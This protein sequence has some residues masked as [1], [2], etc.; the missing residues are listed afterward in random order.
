MNRILI[1]HI[2]YD[3]DATKTAVFEGAKGMDVKSFSVI[4]VKDGETVYSGTPVEVGEVDNWQTGYYY[5]MRFDALKADGEYYISLLAD[6]KEYRSFPFRIAHNLLEM[7][8]I[9]HAGYY[10]K[11][12]RAT[13]EFEA[14]DRALPFRGD[15]PG[16]QDVRGGWFDATGD[17]GIHLSHLSHTTY[18]NPQQAAFSAYAFFKFHDLLEESR[19][20]YYTYLKRRMLDEAM[21]GADFIMRM[22]APSGTFLR[23]KGRTDAFLP[24][25]TSRFINYEYRQPKTRKGGGVLDGFD[26]IK[27]ENYEVSFRSG[28]GYAIATLAYAARTSFP[29]DY[30][31][32]EYLKAAISAYNYLEQNNERYTNDGKWNLIDEYCALD[33][34][35]ELYKT[36]REWDYMRKAGKMAERIMN[37]Y[38][39]IDDTMGYLSVNGTKRPFFHAAD[40]GMPV[41]NLL[42]Y[43]NI[44]ID[45]NLRARVLD[46]VTKLMRH[47]LAV[48]KEVNNPFGYARQLIQDGKGRIETR[49]FY[50]HDVETA[51]WWQ[52]ENARI[53]SLS[54]AARYLTYYTDCEEFKAELNKYADD[55]INWI[56]G[57]NPY[58]SCMME[59]AGRNT[60]EYFFEARRDFIHCPGGIVNGITGGLEDEEHGIAFI[61]EPTDE[62]KDNW[63][64]A[65]QW[66]PHATWYL[67]ALTMKKI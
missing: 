8:T 12:Q 48:T 55:Q 64:W 35:V 40:A 59:G 13:G 50:P 47:E 30:P 42:N 46:I 41:V 24:L 18:F 56:L 5:T 58:D 22:R 32:E 33:A 43:Y 31:K 62:I 45:E 53:A 29:S 34:L 25:Q 63:R 20:P 23:S 67:Y 21:Y 44:E 7:R 9:S 37:R 38:V 15:R 65:E 16:C 52:G 27:D 19:Y 26:E 11:A 66:I 51:P 2:G 4:R 3:T 61:T 36:T 28:G 6:G 49:F 1:N 39:P 14:G 57:L 60:N 10:F 17:I 54:T